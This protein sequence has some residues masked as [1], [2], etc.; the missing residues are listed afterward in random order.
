[1][2]TELR[3]R[4][5]LDLAGNYGEMMKGFEKATQRFVQ[6]THTSLG[7]AQRA[8]GVFGGKLDAAGNNFWARVAGAGGLALAARHVASFDE[9]MTRIGINANAS[10]A[11]VSA[12][13]QQIMQVA[14]QPDIK[15]KIDDLAAG[16]GA[17]VE[18]TGDLDFASKNMQ[19]LGHFMQAT[20]ENAEDIGELIGN[21]RTF[22]VEAPQDILKVV[23]AWTEMGKK[24]GLSLRSMV[25]NGQQVMS[26]YQQ[27][28]RSGPQALREVGAV[29]NMATKQ[30]GNPRRAVSDV[31][32]MLE[33]LN[34]PQSRALTYELGI[35]DM[36]GKMRVGLDEAMRK[37]VQGTH[38]NQALLQHYFGVTGSLVFAPLV[39]EYKAGKPM[40]ALKQYIDV[41]ADG[42]GV[43]DDSA[44]AAREAAE[45]VNTLSNSWEKFA[46]KDLSKPLKDISAEIDKLNPDTVQKTLKGLEYAG[47]G[48]LAIYGARKLWSGI[49]SIWRTGKYILGGKKGGGA[50]GGLAD[51]AGATPVEVVN[52]PGGGL[53]GLGGAA[54]DA[55]AAAGGSSKWLKIGSW[56]AA[57]AVAY[58]AGHYAGDK[59]YHGLM[60]GNA[61][62]DFAGKSMAALWGFLGSDTARNAVFDR[63]AAENVIARG[64]AGILHP[65]STINLKMS[66]DQDGNLRLKG[67]HADADKL[68]L[69]MNYLGHSGFAGAQF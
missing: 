28:G 17:I 1:M 29:L 46:N 40:D 57:G 69:E 14:N 9:S 56:I 58:E 6:G 33:Y 54:G 42:T 67:A 26:I 5:V 24:S 45:S 12:L 68:N 7:V 47:G 51:M 43:I 37:I 35:T 49:G 64:R 62:G 10:A 66:V 44:R 34:N 8:W 21:I 41:T 11:R 65:V 16:V 3:T 19:N 52:W 31:M 4:M 36:T 25:V 32:E 59:V 13:K 23:D 30:L 2:S 38:G 61:S 63:S 53:G 20:G 60:Q 27:L 22:G 39:N 55:E 50:L 15:V 48:L 18:R